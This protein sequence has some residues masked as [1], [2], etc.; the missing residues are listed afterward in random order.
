MRIRILC[1]I[2]SIYIIV[3]GCK[4]NPSTPSAFSNCVISIAEPENYQCYLNKAGTGRKIKLSINVITRYGNYNNS[5]PNYIDHTD[6][7]IPFDPSVDSWPIVVNAEIP[8]VSGRD[9]AWQCEVNVLGTECSTC[10]SGYSDPREVPN[11]A[12]YANY[13]PG[14]NPPV[15][16]AAQP[17]WLA[18]IQKVKYQSTLSILPHRIMNL[19]NSCTCTTP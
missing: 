10:A 6:Q 11:G 16:Y 9:W 18:L 1:S 14:S 12:C 19:P 8:N 13:V 7:T 2:L 15:Y 5:G 17:R 4:F 3:S